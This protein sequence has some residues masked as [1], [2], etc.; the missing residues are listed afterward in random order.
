M[1]DWAK[2]TILQMYYYYYYFVK[3]CLK[4]IEFGLFYFFCFF[5]FRFV[6]FIY[7]FFFFLKLKVSKQAI[8]Y[9]I[10]K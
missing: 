2:Y 7:F 1:E 8:F 6:L 4:P 3:R 9:N 5:F 10:I